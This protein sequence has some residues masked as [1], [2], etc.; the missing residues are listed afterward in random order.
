MRGRVLFG[1]VL[2]IAGLAG[3]AWPVITYTKTEK[4]VDI[5]PIEVTADREKHVPVPPIAGGLAAVAG[6]VII[7]TGGRK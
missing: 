5:G 4:V 7:V 3:L 1:V 6:V 2:L